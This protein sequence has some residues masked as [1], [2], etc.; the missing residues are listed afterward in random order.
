ML[1]YK[2]MYRIQQY[3]YNKHG[4]HKSVVPQRIHQYL[5]MKKSKSIL[6]NI[7]ENLSWNSHFFFNFV[8]Q[9]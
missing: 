8:V 4:R 7:L 2:Y 1:A 9:S 6:K 5:E 3:C